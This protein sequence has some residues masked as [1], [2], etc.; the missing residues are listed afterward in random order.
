MSKWKA[1]LDFLLLTVGK[2]GAGSSGDVG[3]GEWGFV[4][5]GRHF[6]DSSQQISEDLDQASVLFI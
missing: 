3:I 1:A 4:L 5:F 6:K 2:L